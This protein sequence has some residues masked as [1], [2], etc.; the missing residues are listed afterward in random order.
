MLFLTDVDHASV[1]TAKK[2]QRYL[3]GYRRVLKKGRL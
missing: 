2:T 1:E 3:L